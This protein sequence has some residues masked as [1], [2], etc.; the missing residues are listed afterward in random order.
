MTGFQLVDEWTGMPSGQGAGMLQA[1]NTAANTLNALRGLT[2]V[3]ARRAQMEAQRESARETANKLADGSH[4]QKIG[5]IAGK[6]SGLKDN[7][8]DIPGAAVKAMGDKLADGVNSKVD[9]LKKGFQ[10]GK[11]GVDDFVNK[12]SGLD[13]ETPS[14]EAMSEANGAENVPSSAASGYSSPSS[15]HA[16]LTPSSENN[17]IQSAGAKG[18]ESNAPSNPLGSNAPQSVGTTRVPMS[19]INSG[20]SQSNGLAKNP[21]ASGNTIAPNS[22]GYVPN[23]NISDGVVPTRPNGGG[24]YSLTKHQW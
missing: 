11:D 10:S 12:H 1:I 16:D 18:S 20:A 9:D 8:K 24:F 17:S 5:D 23:S 7:A 4:L 6:M 19:G 2:G 22:Q 21:T 13:G 15:A 14:S 3:G